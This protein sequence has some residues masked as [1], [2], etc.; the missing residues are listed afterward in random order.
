MS[1]ISKCTSGFTLIEILVTMFLISGG[2]LGVAAMQISSLNSNQTAYIHTQASL[3]GYEI[4]DRMRSN[5]NNAQLLAASRYVTT[6]PKAAT[7]KESC[8]INCNNS[9]LAENDLYEWFNQ[10]K[11][12]LPGCADDAINDNCASIVIN[13]NN[14]GYIISLRWDE[15]RDGAIADDD[16]IFRLNYEL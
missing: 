12:H 10:I 14:L 1:K 5:I 6:T 9:D 8:A 13:A 15:N 16:P 4:I 3:L 11:A 2:L 7:I